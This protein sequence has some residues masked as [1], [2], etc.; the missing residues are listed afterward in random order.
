MNVLIVGGGGREHALAWKIAQSSRLSK[1]YCAP[2]N[3]GTA[4][5]AENLP[6]YAEDLKA[7]ADAAEQHQIDLTI[8]GPEDPL[9][10]GIADLFD[11]CSLPIIGPTRAAARI[12]AD[13][14]YAKTLMNR[15][16]V[17]T[18]EAR[19]FDDYEHARAYVATRDSALVVKA[20]GLAKGKGVL[21]CQEPAEALIWIEK[22]MV[23]RI[24]GDAGR[25]IVVEE[26]L[27]GQEV[28]VIC[29]V[30]GHNIY[31]LENTQDYKPVGEGDTGP[32]TGGMGS[33]SPADF[34]DDETQTQIERDILVPTV[35]ALRREGAPFRGVLYAGLMLTPGGP[36]VLEFNCR[37]GDPETQPLMMRLESDLLE[38]FEAMRDGRLDQMTLRWSPR[39]AVGVV[40][41]SGGY[42]GNYSK[43]KPISGL[44]T[45][46]ALP[47]VA[48]FHSGT[49]F[50]ND[51]VVTAGGRVL[52]VTALGE[53]LEAARRQAYEAVDQIA[54]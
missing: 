50:S 20:A 40:M 7:L 3:A 23:D 52:C 11:R 15:A 38:V 42:P 36:K 21:L 6:V 17:P 43:G 29:L 26:L 48:V 28:S 16:L 31:V 39:A 5:V 18:A 24:F 27:N 9:A 45:A 34:L 41:A 33:Y 13:K 12:E 4:A 32:N 54:F 19:I 8:V 22:I 53:T 25:R 37:F 10:E 30:D 2:G 51:R 1:L 14:A 46:E 47:D 49:A 44:E 35:E